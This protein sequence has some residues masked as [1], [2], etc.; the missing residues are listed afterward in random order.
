MRQDVPVPSLL[1]VIALFA[2]QLAFIAG[3]LRVVASD[4]AARADP[5]P[6]WGAVECADPS[7]V[8]RIR[9]GGDKHRTASG[10]RQGNRAF[11]RLTVF[12]GDDFFGERCELGQ[13]N[14][15]TS[16]VTFYQPGTRVITFASIRLPRNFPLSSPGPFQV[17]LQMK[18]EAPSNAAGSW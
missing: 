13:N 9:T 3:G 12:D 5:I 4:T 2:T 15:A 10:A 7:R 16:P 14:R 17:V 8:A 11:R 18:Q 6:F 1:S